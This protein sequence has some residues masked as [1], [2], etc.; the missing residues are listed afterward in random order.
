MNRANFTQPRKNPQQAGFS[1]I[2]RALVGHKPVPAT[3]EAQFLRS[4]H[5]YWAMEG[6]LTGAELTT[7]L[8]RIAQP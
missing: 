3:G 6:V 1:G 4:L 7:R 2:R 8:N 5:K